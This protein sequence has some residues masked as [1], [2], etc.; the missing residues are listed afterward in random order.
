MPAIAMALDKAK[1]ISCLNNLH[2]FS[3]AI[4]Q[5]SDDYNG[6]Y[7]P[8]LSTLYKNYSGGEGIYHCRKD[9]N[10]SET[11]SAEWISHKNMKYETSFDRPGN[12][13]LYPLGNDPNT[14]VLNISYYYEFT[15]ASCIW[16]DSTKTCSEL[17]VK[18]MKSGK[19]A[20]TGKKYLLS[21]F[22]IIRCCWHIRKK[23]PVY[24]N[25]S[26]AGNVFY[27]EEEWAAKSWAP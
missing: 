27:S 15:E 5:Y 4:P 1:N 13:S 11:P 16:R 2:Q 25:L 21:F 6:R 9:L 3:L 23:K 24:Q 8:W 14:E 19:N 26:V 20:Y 12:T 17:K 18:D 22:P 7:S 10:S